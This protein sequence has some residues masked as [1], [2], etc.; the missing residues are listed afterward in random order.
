MK[1]L[2]IML[3]GCIPAIAFG[4]EKDAVKKASKV[5]ELK[6]DNG[7]VDKKTAE[8]L[9][10]ATDARLMDS[11]EGKLAA[12]RGTTAEIRS[13][14]QLMVQDQQKMLSAI[15]QLAKRKNISLPDN[16]SEKKA[17]GREELA[18]Q[19]GKDFDEKFIKMMIID[20]KRDVKEF[21]DALLSDDQDVR[22]F[23][24]DYLP[25]IRSHLAKIERIKSAY[26]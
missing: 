24:N 21:E 15:R 17:D 8:F 3:I 16:I 14:G 22:A 11:E 9:V 19:T 25:M 13:Y 5:N 2:Y 4:Q 18:K 12:A 7:E 1:Y 20:H 23:A 26:K 6:A 10:S